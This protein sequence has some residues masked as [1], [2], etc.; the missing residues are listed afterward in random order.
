M[1]FDSRLIV[2]YTFKDH[3]SC[4]DSMVAWRG[5]VGMSGFTFQ[6]KAMISARKGAV[7][8]YQ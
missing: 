3:V 5:S 2:A 8:D 6:Q 1:P 4:L 7:L